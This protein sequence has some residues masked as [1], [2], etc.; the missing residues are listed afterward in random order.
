MGMELSHEDTVTNLLSKR[1]I[2][3]IN[4]EDDILSEKML[5]ANPVYDLTH[6]LKTAGPEPSKWGEKYMFV[7]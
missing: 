4:F 6:F 3:R 5:S 2:L 7:K 1:E